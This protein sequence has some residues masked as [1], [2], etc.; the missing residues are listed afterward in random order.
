[1]PLS[2]IAG[3]GPFLSIA[4]NM[5]PPHLCWIY[6]N[7]ENLNVHM[8]SEK[9]SFEYLTNTV[10]K[11]REIGLNA[12]FLFVNIYYSF[13]RHH[14]GACACALNNTTENDYNKKYV[15]GRD[16]LLYDKL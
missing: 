5:V 4:H 9:Y 16:G 2:T 13:Q 7:E 12:V 14:L 1:M 10:Y 8:K 3:I 11:C 15:T 6:L